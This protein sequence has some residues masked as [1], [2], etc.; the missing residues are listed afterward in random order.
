[1]IIQKIPKHLL[2]E[3]WHQKFVDQSEFVDS[4]D[5]EVNI[6]MI[7]SRLFIVSYRLDYILYY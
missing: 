5:F 7:L 1:M 6:S 3:Y 4:L 2:V